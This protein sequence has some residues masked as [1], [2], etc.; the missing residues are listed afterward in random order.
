M[1]EKELIPEERDFKVIEDLKTTDF[2]FM[3]K[4]KTGVQAGYDKF[5]EKH[6]Y[7][8]LEALKAAV[9]EDTGKVGR[10]MCKKGKGGIWKTE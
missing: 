6:S 7:N 3:V 9:T 4:K 2:I 5:I 1:A 10:V 8:A